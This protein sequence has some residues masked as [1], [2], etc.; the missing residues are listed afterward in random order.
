MVIPHI[1]EKRNNLNELDLPIT[2]GIRDLP[3]RGTSVRLYFFA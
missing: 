3:R 2:L 1:S